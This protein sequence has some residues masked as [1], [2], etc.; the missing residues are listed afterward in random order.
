VNNLKEAVLLL[1][2]KNLL[3]DGLIGPGDCKFPN[4]AA[5]IKESTLTTRHNFGELREEITKNL[6]DTTDKIKRTN[7]E[8]NEL[9]ASTK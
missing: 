5:W 9:L 1:K 8:H 6:K 2:N 3:V 7:T 4:V